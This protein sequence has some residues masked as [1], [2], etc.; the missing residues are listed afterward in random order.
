LIKYKLNLI[1]NRI[2]A[3][4][5]LIRTINND[6]SKSFLDLNNIKGILSGK[7]K[8]G[9]FYNEELVGVILFNRLKNNNYK[10]ISYCTKINYSIIGG[11]NKLI[12]YFIIKYKP[13]SIISYIDKRFFNEKIH[14]YTH[15]KLVGNYNKLNC[16]YFKGYDVY[17][18]IP[19]NTKINDFKRFYDCGEYKYILNIKKP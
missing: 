11:F 6:I 19:K 5:C 15:F 3:K 14:S 16:Y 1:E 13:T 12:K 4:H 17:N 7:I 10:I 8:L 18:N 9:L 2:Y